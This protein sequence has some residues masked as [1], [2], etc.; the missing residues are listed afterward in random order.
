MK[1]T[2]TKKLIILIFI[3][4]I[5]LFITHMDAAKRVLRYLRGS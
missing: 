5:S 4:M 2:N 1:S 3:F